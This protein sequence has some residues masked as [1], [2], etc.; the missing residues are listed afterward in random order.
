[1][2]Q[3]LPEVVPD[4]TA[5]HNDTAQRHGCPL[6]DQTGD[7]ED[8]VYRHLMVNHRKSE[9]SSMLL[10]TTDNRITDTPTQAPDDEVEMLSDGT[11]IH[12]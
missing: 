11:L 10:E 2:S 8:A 7:S 4:D 12:F 9:L 3:S 5:T 6:C 1:M